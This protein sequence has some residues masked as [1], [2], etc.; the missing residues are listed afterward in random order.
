MS[1]LVVPVLIFLFLKGFTT[2]HFDL[3]YFVPQTEPGTQKVLVKGGDTL[4]YQLPD[5]TMHATD[6]K[7]FSSQ[8]L[9]R[10]TLVISTLPALCGDTCQK[11]RDHL[12]RVAAL[13]E[14]Y[15]DLLILTLVNAAEGQPVSEA[16]KAPAW[17][18]LNVPDS[19]YAGYVN[20]IF[21]LNQ[22]IGE[23]QTIL[24]HNQL[25]LL[26]HDGFIRGYYNALDPEEIERL[27][28]EIKILE[29]N[30]KEKNSKE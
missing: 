3:P 8:Q 28:V 17:Q 10:K 26:D 25:E 20:D 11:I 1:T 18:V 21:R 14:A 13:H 24:P 23:E 5:F 2:N 19:L 27:M 12:A 9:A 15:P 7:G 30:R 16:V 29:Y 22:K 4:F 6:G